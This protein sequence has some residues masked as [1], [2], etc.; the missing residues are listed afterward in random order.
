[1]G[2]KSDMIFHTTWISFGTVKEWYGYYAS[3][4]RVIL[5]P[6]FTYEWR[7]FF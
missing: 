4:I 7:E 2:C 1:M 5:I 6:Y 3:K